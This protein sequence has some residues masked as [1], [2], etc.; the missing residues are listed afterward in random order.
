MPVTIRNSF[1]VGELPALYEIEQECF[2]KGFRWTRA[3]F[4]KKFISASK[5]N[6]VW[7][8]EEDGQIMGYLLAGEW[9]GKGY[10][11][12]VNVPKRARRKG[13]ASLLI[14]MYENE[15]KKRGRT[16]IELEVHTDNPAQ[17][18]YFN[19]GYRVI[20]LRRHYYEPDYH[21]LTMRKKL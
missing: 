18:L 17:V 20:R 8:A 13:V 2:A 7:V 9:R 15:A 5:E 14:N 16:E 11:E 12:T 6:N 4:D 10:I 19:L 1:G 3:Y 21:A